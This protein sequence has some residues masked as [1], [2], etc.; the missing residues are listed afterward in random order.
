MKTDP[1]TLADV[2]ADR[3]DLTDLTAQTQA[4]ALGVMS[5]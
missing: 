3:P 2:L 4:W 1:R 5:A